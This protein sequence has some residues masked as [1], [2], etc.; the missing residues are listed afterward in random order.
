MFDINN[1]IVNIS[2]SKIDAV[3]KPCFDFFEGTPY[4][5]LNN[6]PIFSGAGVYAL[7]LKST[8]GLCYEGILPPMHPIY[9][10]KAVPSGSR[11]GL[12]T[13]NNAAL[14]LRLNKHLRSISEARNLRES[15]FLC[16]F[17]ILQGRATDMIGAMES[18]LIR[19]YNPLWN[20]YIDGFG[21]NAPGA[22]R[23][24]QSPSEWDTL[25]PGRYY[26][27]QLTGQPRAIEFIMQK[28]NAYKPPRREY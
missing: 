14:R 9:V 13:L 20:S 18:Y 16:R 11:Q 17:M 7:F 15:D 28:I 27:A 24:N 25:H 12:R 4:F 5:Q 19:Q 8:E 21:I 26:A 1:H 6:L 10:G 23:Y 22:G 2:D 3:V